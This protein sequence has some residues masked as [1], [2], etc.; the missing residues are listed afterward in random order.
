MEIGLISVLGTQVLIIFGL[1]WI[2]SK[3]SLLNGEILDIL[4]ETSRNTS[5][6]R[7]ILERLTE[8]EIGQYKSISKDIGHLK[9]QNQQEHR[10]LEKEIARIAVRKNS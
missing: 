3:V 5:D 9:D 2:V 6:T 7:K 4:K 1:V 10:M 8:I